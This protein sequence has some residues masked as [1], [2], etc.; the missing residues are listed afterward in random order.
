MKK[1]FLTE[2]I[3]KVTGAI[4]GVLGIAFGIGAYLAFLQGVATQIVPLA[5]IGT[6]CLILG[7]ISYLCGRR[8]GKAYSEGR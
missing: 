4:L 1:G 7:I 5:V 8:K 2:K 3:C 6:L